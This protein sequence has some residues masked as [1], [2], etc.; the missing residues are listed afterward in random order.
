MCYP[1]L[2]RLHTT[3]LLS[4]FISLQRGG[5]KCPF[6]ARIGRAYFRVC[7]FCEQ[8]GHSGYPSHPPC[9]AYLN[10]RSI[11]IPCLIRKQITNRCHRIVD[12][13]DVSCR[14]AFGYAGQLFRRR[15]A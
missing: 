10:I 11:H 7:A 5:L 9:P 13:A 15:T 8:E 3:S 1:L 12:G 4:L 14:D 6:T 2:F